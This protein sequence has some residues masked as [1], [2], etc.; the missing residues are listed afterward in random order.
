MRADDHSSASARR[1]VILLIAVAMLAPPG[2]YWWWYQPNFTVTPWQAREEMRRSDKRMLL[3]DV[4]PAAQH[5]VGH[6]EGAQSWPLSDILLIRFSQDLPTALRGHALLLLDDVGGE[7]RTALRHLQKIG[8]ADVRIVRGGIQEWIRSVD[9]VT[10]SALASRSAGEVDDAAWAF[11]QPEL[12]PQLISVAA[13]FVVKPVYT[14][15][16]LIVFVVLW[17]ETSAD[18]TAVKWG[19]L[20]FFIGENMC[21]LNVLVWKETSYLLEYGHSIGMVICLGFLTYAFLEGVDQRILGF[22]APSQRCAGM[23]LC[24]RCVKFT[25]VPCGFRRLFLMLVLACMVVSCMLP[26]TD[27]HDQAYN[28][29]VLG[30]AYHY[31]HLRAFQVLETWGCGVAAFFCFAASLVMVLLSDEHSLQWPKFTFA[32][33]MGALGFG[34]LRTTIGGLYDASRHWYGFWEECTELLLIA[35]ICYVLWTFRAQLLPDWDRRSQA[36][37]TRL[38]TVLFDS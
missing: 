5:G 35:A 36:W 34:L 19:M 9:G 14:L 20:F 30:Q 37:R 17:G 7:S 21:A 23:G 1:F 2:V 15:L 16:S 4:R 10:D 29:L 26:A 11:R 18:L 3:V 32:A 13:F 38:E 22:S 8:G 28:T 27:W 31:G 24:G 12:I 33:G 6:I 25:E